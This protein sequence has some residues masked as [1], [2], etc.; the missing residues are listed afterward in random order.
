MERLRVNRRQSSFPWN[1]PVTPE[2]AGSSPVAPEENI[3]QISLFCCPIRRK[4]LPASFD[5]ALIPQVA[6]KG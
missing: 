3:L 5:P 1:M 4:R 6:E 2:V